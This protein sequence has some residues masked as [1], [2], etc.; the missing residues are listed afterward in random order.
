MGFAS[1]VFSV[2]SS[3]D[4]KK[5]AKVV[6]HINEL[7]GEYKSMSDT[8]LVARNAELMKKARSGNAKDDEYVRLNAMALLREH[9]RRYDGRRAFDVQLMAALALWDGNIIE[10]QTGEGKTL[11]SHFPAYLGALYGKQVHVITVNEYLTQRDADEALDL[12]KGFNITVGRIYNQQPRFEKQLAYKADI[13]YGTPSEFGFDY[14]RDNMVNEI[15]QKVQK[16]HDYVVIDEVDSILIDEA[17]TPLIISGAGTSSSST[18]IRFA[19]AV[20]GLSRDV[21]YDIEEDKKQIATTEVGL[22]KVEKK[23]GIKVFDDSTGRMANHLMQ[24]LKAEYLFHK[25]KDYIVTG[26]EVKIVDENTGRIMEGRRWSEGLHQAIEAKEGV[27][28]QEENQTLAT[29]TLQNYFRLYDKI[30]GM[31]GTALSEAKEFREIYHVETIGIPTNKDILRKDE[32]D[33]IYITANAKY[34]AIADEI[35]RAHANG[36]PVLAGTISVENSER[37]SRLL[38][39]RQ[40][41]HSVLNAKYH[42]KEAEIIAQAG[43]L[44]AVTIAT[45][46]AG[47]GTD[48]ILGGNV[49][50]MTKMIARDM[51]AERVANMTSEQRDKL[52]AA[53]DEPTDAELSKAKAQAQSI[54]DVEH[55]KVVAAGGLYVIGSE[56]HD[57][58]RIDNQLRGRSGRQ[59]DPGRS[60]FFI[61][62]EDDL[63]KLFGDGAERI[64]TTLRNNGIAEDEPIEMKI[65]SKAI[66]NAQ[67]KVEQINY[68]QR[69]HTLE[70]DDVINKQRK[71]MYSARDDVLNGED[72]EAKA[73]DI[74][75]DE[76]SNAFDEYAEAGNSDK[77]DWKGLTGWYFGLTGENGGAL[78]NSS[79]KTSRKELEPSVRDNITSRYEGKRNLV[80]SNSGDKDTLFKLL[81]DKVMLSVIDKNWQ[82]HLSSMEYLRVGIGLRG[83]GQRDPLVE[84]KQEAYRAF[85]LLIDR[86]YGEYLKTLLHLRISYDEPPKQTETYQQPTEPDGDLDQNNDVSVAS[87]A[88]R[89]QFENMGHAKLAG[90]FYGDS[91]TYRKDPNDPYANVGRNDPCPCGSGKKF[92]NCHG[93]N[94]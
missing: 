2:G 84:Y 25:N 92:K 49:S 61:S 26:G 89:S 16:S 79:E 45:N 72:L 3:K 76:V 17:R 83:V 34:E 32:P 5:Y 80:R 35:E 10:A 41:K 66:E 30:S 40:I 48:I 73:A 62:L 69:K 75:D 71:L 13:V 46:M 12:L 53:A 37:L 15:G 60:R 55:P 11:M 65:A 21:D 28:V 18:Y 82:G 70:Y 6:K 9:I 67:H 38:D 81:Q 93:R 85:Q 91:K 87:D 74:I 19:K 51:A 7:E 90:S 29:I 94:R 63:M 52:G 47:R 42:A 43:R 4:T 24:A 20:T 88:P 14:L 22:S 50:G 56:R 8:E 23:L 58:R 86:M 57:A 78:F 77:W 44:G 64:T 33:V 31:T 1:K 36:Q 54:F 68:E 27:K 39:K 59:G